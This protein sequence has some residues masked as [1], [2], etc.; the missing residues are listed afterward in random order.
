MF[1][2]AGNKLHALLEAA[3]SPAPLTGAL[4]DGVYRVL[5]WVV[6]V[7]LPPMAIF[8][9]LFTLL[10]DFGYL[11]RVAFNLDHSFQKAG[12]CGKQALTMCMGFGCNAAGVTGCR[13]I[14]SP[15]ERLIA[16]V[17]NNFV[18]CNGRFPTIISIISMFFLGSIAAPLDSVLSAV[19]LALLIALAVGITFAVSRLLSKTILKGIPSSFTL[20]LPPYRRPQIGKVIIRSIFDRTLFVLGRA[21][22]VAAP[23]GLLIWLTANIYIGGESIFAHC[24]GFLDPAARLFG[25]DG[26]ILL[27]FIL[28]FPA[29]ETVLPIILMGYLATGTLTELGSTEV[30]RELL[31][32]NGWTWV[33]AVCV[34]LFSLFHWPCSTTCITIKK[35]T[36][37]LKWALLSVALPTA[38]G[39]AIC[40]IVN[41]T[42]NILS[43]V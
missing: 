17:T 43:L 12:A 13:I 42:S 16:A 35:E 39:L 32:A 26:I 10:E 37:S 8:F 19:L 40:F 31:T 2:A 11:P 41:Q 34:I 3:G 33:T 23:A 27:A 20:E 22:A 14:D 28:G 29:N 15:R 18:P 5:T 6:S 21:A 30:M 24:A 9:P 4:M 36:G 38:V 7:M 1:A 25:M